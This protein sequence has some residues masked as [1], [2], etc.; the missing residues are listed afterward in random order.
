MEA[1]KKLKSKHADKQM[2]PPIS[3]VSTGQRH[4]NVSINK[5]QHNKHQYQRGKVH[6]PTLLKK[7]P[8][9]VPEHQPDNAASGSPNS[10]QPQLG[11]VEPLRPHIVATDSSV[12]G[13]MSLVCELKLK[14]LKRDGNLL[15]QTIPATD[16][17]LEILREK[18]A[19]DLS[20][21][22]ALKVSLYFVFHQSTM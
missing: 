8:T 10:E 4:E 22:H 7:K 9:S 12:P 18:A 3:K 16:D 20:L 19:L 21:L 11:P 17:V 1:G 2:L 14:S 6:H 13:K 15:K 5:N